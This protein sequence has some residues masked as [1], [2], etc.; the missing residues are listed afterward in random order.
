MHAICNKIEFISK[1]MLQKF[2]K[3]FFD[4]LKKNKYSLRCHSKICLFCLNK[5]ETRMLNT[6]MRFECYF[7]KI[8]YF[9]VKNKIFE[10][11]HF[12]CNEQLRHIYYFQIHAIQ[13]HEIEFIKKCESFFQQS[14]NQICEYLKLNWTKLTNYDIE[15]HF[16]KSFDRCFSFFA[17]KLQIIFLQLNFHWLFSRVVF[18]NIVRVFFFQTS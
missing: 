3:R 4:D 15:K 2:F 12:H 16:L 7:E 18:I 13:I 17:N 10:C 6:R 9:Y 1:K 14:L 8:H 5:I 11:F